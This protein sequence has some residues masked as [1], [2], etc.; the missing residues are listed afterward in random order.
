ME[1]LQRSNIIVITRNAPPNK[2]DTLPKGTV[3]NVICK[4][5]SPQVFIQR[6]PNEEKPVWEKV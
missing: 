6:S 2:L 1:A 5:G 4:K 3:C